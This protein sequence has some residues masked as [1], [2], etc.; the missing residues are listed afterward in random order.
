[1]VHAFIAYLREDEP[2]VE[3]LCRAL[4][5]AGIEYWRD[6]EELRAG[7][8]W[9]DA[10]REAVRAGAYF[11]GC[12]SAAF[13]TKPNSFLHEEVRVALEVLGE[14]ETTATSF[15]S[16][17]ISG[18]LP[19]LSIGGGRSLRD[20]QCVD[21]RRDWHLG[22]AELVD[23]IRSTDG[24]SAVRRIREIESCYE[25]AGKEDR[26]KL[27]QGMRDFLH[28]PLGL[29]LLQRMAADHEEDIGQEALRLLGWS[30]EL[31]AVRLA[32]LLSDPGLSESIRQSAVIG[33][34]KLR[35]AVAVPALVRHLED[36]PIEDQGYV[37][38][39]LA[40]IR[41]PREKIL[42]ALA[43][44]LP[45][46]SEAREARLVA[47]E[48]LGDK[49]S[50][51]LLAAEGRVEE[52]VDMLVD[53][54]GRIRARARNKLLDLG[55][56]AVPSLAERIEE[57]EARQTIVD[58]GE[59]AVPYLMDAL[60]S[61]SR[62][63]DD[64]I[65]QALGEIGDPRAVPALRAA[66][67]DELCVCSEAAVALARIDGAAAVPLLAST[68]QSRVVLTDVFL[69]ALVLVGTVEALDALVDI[70]VNPCVREEHSEVFWGSDA[71][72]AAAAIVELAGTAAWPA[73]STTGKQR[74]AR[75][76][77]KALQE[78]E[79]RKEI[80]SALAVCI[81]GNGQ[82]R[83][84]VRALDGHCSHGRALDVVLPLLLRF[85]VPVIV[86]ELVDRFLALP[87][88]ADRSDLERV[89]HEAVG[90][91]GK[92]T[93]ARASRSLEE[94]R[95]LAKWIRRIERLLR[96]VGARDLE[97]VT[98]LLRW[99]TLARHVDTEVR[100]RAASLRS[101]LEG[102]G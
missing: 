19:E 12:F 40:E 92:A 87:P 53:G 5:D 51:D 59:P 81:Q 37:V 44:M 3:M 9:P 2:T 94:D 67:I 61:P 89:L 11:V 78:P 83:D 86:P 65:A 28:H 27:V 97:P 57:E 30:E 22:M 58:I 95:R 17:L 15:I 74:A 8:L 36:G 50:L 77:A 47:L 73:I 49:A 75:R 99:R 18:E 93:R 80:A 82:L 101:A 42:A 14:R 46:T 1:M 69:R 79:Q 23:A 26:G 10:I 70:A 55:V 35:A 71:R 84:I 34:G 45:R 62:G 7:V 21:V 72:A 52:L 13:A 66:I 16:V 68:F 91:R 31:G 76:L 4:S 85:G 100:G 6:R 56:R 98:A 96:A 90:S 54:E 48:A 33:L 88:D 102:D 20:L 25:G 32:R 38:S 29:D 39:T 41:E 64:A 43:G 60:R 63:D 24:A